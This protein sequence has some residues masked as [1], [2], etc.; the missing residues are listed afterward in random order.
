VTSGYCWG[1]VG[2][3]RPTGR[4][5]SYLHHRYVLRVPGEFTAGCPFAIPTSMFGNPS[6]PGQ[7]ICLLPFKFVCREDSASRNPLNWRS[8]MGMSALGHG[9]T[10]LDNLLIANTT[11]PSHNNRST[12]CP[13]PIGDRA[14]RRRPKA[15]LDISRHVPE[16]CREPP[17]RAAPLVQRRRSPLAIQVRALAQEA[18]P[19]MRRVR[20]RRSARQ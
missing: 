20:P 8:C 14:L 15:A 12:T 9:D 4:P 11:R 1:E 10:D 19:P 18:A 7:Q 5:A 6:H 2:F 13:R 17:T 16:A 3:T